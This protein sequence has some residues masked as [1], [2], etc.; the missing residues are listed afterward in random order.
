MIFVIDV[1]M[2]VMDITGIVILAIQEYCPP[3]DV[4]RGLNWRVRVVVLVEA[5]PEV[6]EMPFPPTTF[7]PFFNHIT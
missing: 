7:E 6:T 1:L 3:L 5:I 2:L 4:W